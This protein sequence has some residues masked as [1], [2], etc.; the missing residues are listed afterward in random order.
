[1]V[2]SS[3]PDLISIEWRLAVF[4]SASFCFLPLSL[5]QIVCDCP[6]ALHDLAMADPT[7]KLPIDETTPLLPSSDTNHHGNEIGTEVGESGR[8][9]GAENVSGSISPKVA[10][11]ILTIGKP[12]HVALNDRLTML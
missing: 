3:Q 12:C 2:S 1:M 10:V 4:Q 6:C 11:A 9:D 5:A 7:I 8:E